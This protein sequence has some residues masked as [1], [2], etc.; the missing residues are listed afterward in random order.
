MSTTERFRLKLFSPL[1]LA[2]TWA[3]ERPDYVAGDCYAVA[4]TADAEAETPTLAPMTLDEIRVY[5]AGRTDM[6][7]S[8]IHDCVGISI[9]DQDGRAVAF[10]SPLP[11]RNRPLDVRV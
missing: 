1:H 6:L 8:Q 11:V 3:S 2:I 10:P 7:G 4:F 9:Q 5:I